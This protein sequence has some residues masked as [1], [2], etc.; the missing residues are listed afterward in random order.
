MSPCPKCFNLEPWQFSNAEKVM[1]ELEVDNFPTVFTDAK[2]AEEWAIDKVKE[3][4]EIIDIM[5]TSEKTRKDAAIKVNDSKLKIKSWLDELN[6]VPER[7]GLDQ[8][9]AEL[10]KAEG[11]K[12]QLGVLDFKKKKVL[13]EKINTLQ[14]QI[15]NLN[16]VIHRKTTPLEKRILK[17]GN[18]LIT[19]QSIAFGY[20]DKIASKEVGNTV[21]YY[22]S[23]N[24]SPTEVTSTDNNPQPIAIEAS[25]APTEDIILPNKF[26][27][28]D[29]PVFCRKCGFKLLDNSS[30]CTKC[31][32]KVD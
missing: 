13:N 32:T 5:R 19:T 7:D 21:S 9:K 20:S 30:F 16:D 10:S 15:K 6:S 11:L 31:G 12:P 2:E 4:M 24:D 8:L 23:P 17:L 28:D 25:I 27:T 14:A 26:I 3:H 29:K 1:D 22:I 18:E